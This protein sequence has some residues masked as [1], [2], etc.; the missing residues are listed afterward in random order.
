MLSGLP[1]G[2]QRAS[3]S[4]VQPTERRRTTLPMGQWY[5]VLRES[6]INVIQ[7]AS[8]FRTLGITL[9]GICDEEHALQEQRDRCSRVLEVA[10][11][12]NGFRADSLR[13]HDSSHTMRF[14]LVLYDS[15]EQQRAA[16]RSFK[17]DFHFLL[18]MEEHAR[19]DDGLLEVLRHIFLAARPA[20][21]SALHV[22]GST[23]R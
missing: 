3:S 22:V 17:E 23:A 10:L 20:C 1:L 19:G 5:F 21:A 16:V 6:L 7:T 13:E 4:T 15:W 12:I 14:A 18:Q 9:G 8:T 11:A 2:L